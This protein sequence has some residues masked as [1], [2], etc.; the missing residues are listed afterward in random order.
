MCSKQIQRQTFFPS[1]Q[2][3][4]GHLVKTRGVQQEINN[5]YVNEWSGMKLVCTSERSD[6]KPVSAS[7]QADDKLVGKR[8][9]M[10]LMTTSG[11]S[12]IKVAGQRK[13]PFNNL[14]MTCYA[15]YSNGPFIHP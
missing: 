7:G 4:S 3:S 8:S 1:G 12:D 14:N 6:M 15:M 9:N 2:L 13:T 11:L 10:K 5:C